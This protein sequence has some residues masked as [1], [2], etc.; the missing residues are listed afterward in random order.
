MPT[1]RRPTHTQ[2]YTHKRTHIQTYRRFPQRTSILSD[3][4]TFTPPYRVKQKIGTEERETCAR[5]LMAHFFER[6][7][8]R[9]AK[10]VTRHTALRLA[11][12]V[13]HGTNSNS[14]ALRAQT[15][16]RSLRGFGS[17]LETTNRARPGGTT[18]ESMTAAPALESRAGTDV[19]VYQRTQ[20]PNLT[21]LRPIPPFSPSPFPS[22]PTQGRWNVSY[23]PAPAWKRAT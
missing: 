12:R 20:P 9:A 4:H 17:T 21:R 10:K 14:P 16:V 18:R 22:F 5:S 23:G 13:R 7:K 3:L 19:Q 2:T 15:G 6:P 8:K 1:T 11:L